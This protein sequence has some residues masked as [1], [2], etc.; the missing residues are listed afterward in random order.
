MAPGD[1]QE[2]LEVL[3]PG[4]SP[5]PS[6]LLVGL[7]AA[8]DAAVYRIGADVAIVETGGFFPPVVDDRRGGIGRLHR[9]AACAGGA[10]RTARGA[11]QEVWEVRTRGGAPPPAALPGGL[12]AAGEAAVSRRG[13]G[14]GI[15]ETV[16]SSPPVVDD[17]REEID[18][19]DDRD[20]GA[21]A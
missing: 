8:D 2:V 14:V 12:G 10:S 13:A 5:P 4:G 17:R 21:D 18:R 15:G 9:D 6:D 3:K 1:L 19:L 7:G 20:V 11:H 16:V